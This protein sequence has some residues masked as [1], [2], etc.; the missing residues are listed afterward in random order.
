MNEADK[1]F[2]DNPL[3]AIWIR[4]GVIEKDLKLITNELDDNSL[5]DDSLNDDFGDNNLDGY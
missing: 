5:G 3:K 4:L 1:L 2:L